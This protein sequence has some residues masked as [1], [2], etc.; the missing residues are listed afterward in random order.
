MS[1]YWN[2]I[3][4]NQKIEH[5]ARWAISNQG[6]PI[7]LYQR[8][9]PNIRPFLF[10]GGVHGDEPEG[11]E[12][13]QKFLKWLQEQEAI[14][15][16]VHPWILVPCLNIDGYT[17]NN[18]LNGSG[19]D[20]NRNFPSHDWSPLAATPR[21]QP[22]PSPGSEPEIKAVVELI[23]QANPSL[24][25]HFHSWH[26]CIV[27]T[28][29]L[30][31]LPAEFIA[32]RTPYQAKEDIGY[33]TPGS[34]GQYGWLNHQTPVI[35]IEEQND[36]P[37][38]EVWG[39]FDK[40]LP[41]LMTQYMQ[42]IKVIAIDL[43]D[44]VLDTTHLVVPASARKSC[45]ILFSKSKPPTPSE[46]PRMEEA[47]RLR[48]QMA[49]GNSHRVI[50]KKIA[51]H[52]NIVDPDLIDKATQSFYRPELPDKLPLI[53]G[54][55]ENIHYLKE[56]YSLYLVTSGDL[57]TQKNK[58]KALGIEPYF[59]KII[60]CN[61]LNEE[62]KR[63]AFQTIIKENNIKPWQMLSIGNRLSSETREA[64]KCGALTCHFA[65]GEHSGEI[66]IEPEDRPDFTITQH[67]DLISTCRL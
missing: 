47:L 14:G 45:E 66:P 5:K 39:H 57:E 4:M 12:L 40:A 59:K 58:V 34:L 25:V 64:K 22:G 48:T 52:F 50:F 65:F 53:E 6:R 28:G 54:A 11:V 41:D 7:E 63:A 3:Y 23:S 32:E 30:G 60:I 10:I 55:Q 26:P 24:I 36:C 49:Q 27:Y 21:Y 9:T 18:R 35:C 51:A 62:T 44:T 33:P 42:D 19:V 61:S 67:S 46:D 1:N 31:A 29:Y 37:L 56:K 16:P 15:R 17:Q 2:G 38:D 8:L 13:A 43:D 20:L